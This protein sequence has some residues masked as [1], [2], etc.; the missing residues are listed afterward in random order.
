MRKVLVDLHRLGGNK[1]NGLYHFSYQ[2]GK[3]LVS[4]P[5]DDMEL[6]FY[7]PKTQFGIFGK[8]I[9][10]VPQRSRDKYYRFGTRKF[11]IWHITTAISWYR[12]FNKKTKNIFTIHDLNFLNEEEYKA[13]SRKNYLQLIQQRVNRADY[14]TFISNFAYEQ[15]QQHLKLGDKPFSVIHNGCNVPDAKGINEPEHS[16]KKPF[17]FS[18]GQLHSRKNFHVLPPLLKGNDDELIIAGIND[19]LYAKKVMDEARRHNVEKRVRLIGTVT[20][21]EK[22]WYFKNCKAFVFPSMGEGFGLPVIEAMYFGKPVFLSKHTSLPEVGGDAAYYFD[23]FEPESMHASFEKGMNDFSNN[24]NRV[25]AVQQQ[26]ALFDWNK[27]AKEYLEVY[28]SLI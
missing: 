8:K 12:P 21:N 20:E 4:S 16:P 27:N 15:A 5:H 14:L 28:R 26:A 25:A 2:L 22:H 24:D 23:D 6:H 10:Y 11:D 3:H 19:T 7:L 9:F 1:F 13:G 18:I 17:L